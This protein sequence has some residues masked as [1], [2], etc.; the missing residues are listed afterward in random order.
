ARGGKLRRIQQRGD[1][2]LQLRYSL[3]LGN[4]RCRRALLSQRGRNQQT[5]D[6]QQRKKMLGCFHSVVAIV[7]AVAMIGFVGS[8]NFS[9]TSIRPSP[10]TLKY[11]TKLFSKSA[12]QKQGLC[13]R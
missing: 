1:T 5:E 4:E 2:R 12:M 9:A 11:W 13:F 8:G 3:R 7:A 10:S 6:D